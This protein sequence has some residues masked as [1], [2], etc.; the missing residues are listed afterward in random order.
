MKKLVLMAVAVMMATMSVNAQ[1]EEQ[2]P[3]HEISVGYGAISNADFSALGEAFGSIIG[4]F[5]QVTYNN[6]SITGPISLEY[7]YHV[8]PIIGVGGVGVYANEKK[9]MFFQNEKV[10]DVKNTYISVMPS[11]KFNWLRTK[12]FGMYSKVAAGLCFVNKKSN[13][14]RTSTSAAKSNSTN[15]TM[16]TYQLTGIGIEAGPQNIRAFAELGIGEQGIL[17]AGIRCKF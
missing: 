6:G 13:E 15:T 1:S 3:K 12:Y 9:D 4:S 10:G 17:L 7:Y 14:D 11:V 2:Y 5:G 8:T 16:F